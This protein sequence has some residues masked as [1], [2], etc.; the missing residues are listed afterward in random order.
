[1]AIRKSAS[2]MTEP[3]RM[4]SR[5]FAVL[6]FF[7]P[8]R[9]AEQMIEPGRDAI[10]GEDDQQIGFRMEAA[11]EKIADGHADCDGSGKH[12]PDDRV[13]DPTFVFSWFVVHR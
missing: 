10:E 5:R 13:I 9:H 8:L 7:M 12:Q 11:V 4:R 1:M 3:A 6:F 2:L